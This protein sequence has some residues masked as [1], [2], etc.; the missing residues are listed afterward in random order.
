MKSQ[1]IVIREIF[2][3]IGL[4]SIL[5]IV[6]IGLLLARFINVTPFA[7][8]I[9]LSSGIT[10]VFVVLLR[11]TDYLIFGWFFLTTFFYFIIY[12]LFPGVLPSLYYYQLLGTTIFWGLLFCVIAAW[13]ID[14]AI[15][16]RKFMPLADISLPLVAT[17]VVFLLWSALTLVSSVDVFVSV[18]KWAHIVIALGASYMFY[19]FFARDENNIRKMLKVVS[20]LVIFVSFVVLYA[21]MSRL[22]LGTTIYKTISMWFWNPNIVG[23]FLFTFTPI[24]ITSGFYFKPVKRLR[25]VFLAVVLLSLFFS[26]GRT[27]WLA[28]LVSI[29]FL[30]WKSG[31]QKSAL[32]AGFVGVLVLAGMTVP[33]WRE[34]L[35]DFITGPRYTGRQELWRAAWNV[36]CDYPVL[37]T[38]LGNC[39]EFMNQYIDVP[40]L[41]NQNT[42]NAYLRNAADMG[43]LS[44][45][46]LLAF[47][48]VFF[49]SST[50]IEKTLKSDFLKLAVR[51]TIATYLG[52]FVHDMFGNGSILTCF[53]AA[54][55]HVLFPYILMALPFAAKKLEERGEAG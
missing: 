5:G 10:L 47:Y 15:S 12:S 21:A 3:R 48:F 6:L 41:R 22:I 54:E 44:A 13:A 55:S 25:F 50:R 23:H 33:L 30:L 9:V 51:G 28:A 11:K 36:A 49:W 29:A 46:L 26:F 2:K 39:Q 37:G 52:M 32:A 42:H 8:I 45:V 53:V 20:L 24:L 16:G 34:P 18:K 1:V 35:Y 38:G 40:W 43:F 27:S 17:I 31:R 7:A 4:A 19:D 14:N